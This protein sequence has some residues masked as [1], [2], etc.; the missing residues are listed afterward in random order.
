METPWFHYPEYAWR[1]KTATVVGAGIAGHQVARHLAQRGWRVTLIERHAHYPAEASGNAAAILSPKIT[2]APSLGEHF[3]THCFEYAVQQL[4]DIPVLTPYWHPCG[5]LT[6]CYRE[7]DQVRW[8]KLKERDFP[9]DVLRC[10]NP[11]QASK[12]AQIPVHDPALYFPGA[13]WLE[14]DFICE[15]LGFHHLIHY[16]LSTEAIHLKYRNAHWEVWNQQQQIVALSEALIICSGHRLNF[17]AVQDLPAMPVAG[18]TT[19]ATSGTWGD[20]L[21]TVIDHEGYITPKR[22][23]TDQG[24]CHL[25]G[26]SY[27][28]GNSHARYDPTTDQ[29]NIQ[30]QQCL[31]ELAA[32]LTPLHL[33]GHAAIRMTTPDRFP[34]VGAVPKRQAYLQSYAD[35]HHG[36]HWKYYPPAA[37]YPNLFIA[38][39][40]GSHGFTTAALC[41]NML[42]C[43]INNE[44]F[45]LDKKLVQALHPARFWIRKL[46]QEGSC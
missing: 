38:A 3:Y 25:M 14:P 5:V 39:A 41:A 10:V 42:A 36:R 33:Q 15:G 9:A 44:P 7:R 17:P 43:L 29:Q 37:Y 2:A 35:L 16:K 40:F 21:R 23:R 12:I 20:Q 31:P 27:E 18:Q 8:R 6:L 34:Y 13:G 24:S 22:I 19:L 28:P 26:A 4:T 45:P 11:A 30:K 46:K 32:E 1:L